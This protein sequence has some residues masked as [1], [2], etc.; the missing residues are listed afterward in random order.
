MATI[1]QGVVKLLGTIL[2]GIAIFLIAALLGTAISAWW[3]PLP[4]AHGAVD[5]CTTTTYINPDGTI[6]ICTQCCTAGY[7]TVTC[8]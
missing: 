3:Y 1:V 7:C 5:G 4:S 8:F 6:F 2:I